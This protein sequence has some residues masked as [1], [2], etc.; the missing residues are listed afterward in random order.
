L[1]RKSD[2]WKRGAC[3][4]QWIVLPPTALNISGVIADSVSL[5]G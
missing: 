1:T 2:G 3:A 5:T 4:V